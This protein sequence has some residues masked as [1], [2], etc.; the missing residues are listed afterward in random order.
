METVRVHEQLPD[1]CSAEQQHERKERKSVLSVVLSLV[2]SVVLL[3]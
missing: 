2:L 3:G 1:A